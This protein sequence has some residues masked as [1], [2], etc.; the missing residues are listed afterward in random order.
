MLTSLAY[1]LA[2]AAILLIAAGLFFAADRRRHIPLMFAAFGCDMVGLVLVEI[3]IPMASGH[4]DPLTGLFKADGNTYWTYIHAALA[5]LTVV[6]YVLQ[7]MSGR[8][9]ARG[10][11]GVLLRHKKVA[12]YFVITRVLAYITMFV[13]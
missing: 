1:L 13:A 8:R 3:V 7:I 5:T 9:L 11:R 6:G 4:R 12:R 2:T 10:E